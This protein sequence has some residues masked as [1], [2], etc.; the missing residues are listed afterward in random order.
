MNKLFL[1]DGAAGAGKSDLVN[2]VNGSKHNYSI[3]ILQ[4][5]TTR[6][7]REKEKAEEIELTFISKQE[8]AE[9]ESNV[10]DF[11]SYQYYGEGYGFK[12]SD[13]IY[14]IST[15]EFTFVII[16]DKELIERIKKELGSIVQIIHVFVYTDEGLARERLTKEGYTDEEIEFRLG[17]IESVWE[18]YLLYSNVYTIINNSSITD[19]HTKIHTMI[20]EYAKMNEPS[21]LLFIN[22][23]TKFELID[24]LVG[25]KDKIER[26]LKKYPYDQN[27]FLMMKFR[28]NNRTVYKF[29]KNRLEEKGLNCVRADAVE[30]KRLTNNV[31]NPLA[32]LY[33]CKYGIALFDEAEIKRIGS[34]EYM[35]AYTQMLLTNWVL[36]T[37][38]RNN[39]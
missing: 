34:K 6:S 11:Y 37:T 7:K 28:D 23:S 4:K 18:D 3:S 38:K 31:Y 10:D 2:F 20:K 5:V 36:C 1:I 24:P 26:Q 25:F 33:C 16:R 17:R 21:N 32:V 29:I 12:K 22:P 19:F 39:V 30:W 35:I 15:Y 14:S 13:L 8:F 9:L 27:V